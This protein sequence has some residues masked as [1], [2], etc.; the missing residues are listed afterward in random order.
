MGTAAFNRA[1]NRRPSGVPIVE[2]AIEV[3][4]DT[5]YLL[6]SAA[7]R[8]GR[9]QHIAVIAL[10][11]RIVGALQS[12]IPEPGPGTDDTG[13]TARRS[14]N[15]NEIRKEMIHRLHGFSQVKYFE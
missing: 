13:V 9:R 3:G 11:P 7:E 1:R 4:T 15:Q 12:A 10:D 5:L 8:Q 14:R 6:P 2:S